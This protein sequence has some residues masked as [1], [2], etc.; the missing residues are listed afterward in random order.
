MAEL[1]P[2]NAPPQRAF[3][4]RTVREKGYVF[5]RSDRV[6]QHATDYYR[7][8]ETGLSAVIVWGEDGQVAVAYQQEDDASAQ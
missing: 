8:P 4:Q 6:E 5:E 2:L 7:H 1:I 3:A